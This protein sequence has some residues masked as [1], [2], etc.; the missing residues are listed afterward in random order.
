MV[1]VDIS[2]QKLLGKIEDEL[3][4]AKVSGSEA[5]RRERIHAI[6]ALCELA[7]DERP[8]LEERSIPA[9][10]SSSSPVFQAQTINVAGQ[11]QKMEIDDESN[12]ESLFDF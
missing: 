2:I 10:Y 8:K 3:K 1:N 4:Q 9:S 6:K 11:P 12:G 5:H 7:L